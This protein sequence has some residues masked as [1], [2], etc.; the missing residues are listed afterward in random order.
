MAAQWT[1]LH[2][3]VCQ[4]LYNAALGAACFCFLSNQSGMPIWSRQALL[5]WVIKMWW[6][7]YSE[8]LSRACKLFLFM[9]FL[10]SPP[11]VIWRSYSVEVSAVVCR[12]GTGSNLMAISLELCCNHWVNLWSQEFEYSLSRRN[13]L[14]CNTPTSTMI[15][16][17]DS[18]YKI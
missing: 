16:I 3:W 6:Q 8:F 13:L 7:G 11:F 17:S 9:Y 14:S 4:S 2:I 10:P 15:H 12:C 18:T 5:V 1:C